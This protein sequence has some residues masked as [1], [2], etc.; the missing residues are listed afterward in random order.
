MRASRGRGALHLALL[1]SPRLWACRKTKFVCIN[2]DMKEAPPSVVALLHDFYESYFPK[3]SAFELPPGQTNPYLYISDLRAHARQRAVL[4]VVRF[5]V[6]LGGCGWVLS[7]AV[8]KRW[9]PTGGGGGGG[10]GA[11][12]GPRSP[13]RRRPVLASP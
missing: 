6:C 5:L 4:K 2:D 7:R 8:S 12:S 9:S 11:A 3:P 13:S 1:C 10:G